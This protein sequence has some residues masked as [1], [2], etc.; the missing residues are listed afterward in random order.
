MA[1]KVVEILSLDTKYK[2]D[3]IKEDNPSNTRNFI[4]SW[5]S[6]IA[7]FVYRIVGMETSEVEAKESVNNI[8]DAASLI[9]N[10]VRAGLEVEPLSNS[11]V[12]NL[13]YMSENPAL[14]A[15]I[16]DCIV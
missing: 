11:R 4:S 12:V 16:A 14:A 2:S 15:L 5:F 6:K 10:I 9:T 3:F 7:K 8:K 1:R 13:S